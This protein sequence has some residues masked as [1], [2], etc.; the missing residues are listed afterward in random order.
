MNK[1]HRH[2]KLSQY[3]KLSVFIIIQS[4][5]IT[6]QSGHDVWEKDRWQDKRTKDLSAPLKP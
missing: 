6:L 1:G 3:Q 4:R 5:V 2:D